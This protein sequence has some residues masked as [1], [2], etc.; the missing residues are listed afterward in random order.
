MKGDI[1]VEN[2]GELATP[3]GFSARRGAEMDSLRIVKKAL[4]VA[5]GGLVA[6]A[7]PA[8]D[9]EGRAALEKA[10]RE[11]AACLD[12]AGRA[13]VPGFVDSHTHFLFAGFRADEFFWRAQGLPYMEIHR[14][15][16]G[17]AK[18]VEAT[19]RC[20]AEELTSLGKARLD[21]M[22]SIGVTTVEGKSGYGL[23]KDTE[24]RQL[25]AMGAL[26]RLSPARVVRT[27]MGPHSLPAEFAGRPAEYIDF[28]I[29]E[30]LPE[31]AARKLADFADIFCEE[32]VFGI[33]DSRRYLSAARASGLGIKIH[34]DEIVRTG[35]ARLAAELGATSADHLLKAAP[36][37]FK[38]MAAAGTIAACLP[39]TAFSLREAYAD[40]RAMVDSGLAVA[41]ASDLNPGSC[42]SQSIPLIFAIAILSMKLSFAETLTAL[43]LNGAAALGLAGELGSLERGKKADFLILDAPEAAHLAYHAAMNIVSLTAIGGE[44]VYRQP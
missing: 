16:G 7:G 2:I 1:I 32:G 19:R 6:Y 20:S 28:V 31:V 40:A 17:I 43:T 30:V 36:E 35:G 14:R 38:A 12:A 23:D 9:S 44:I 4:L 5:R 10:R 3:V 37:D 26:A 39:L 8:E 33:E 24:L 22:L 21:T 11:G 41:L 42:Y 29:G 15:G 27:F 34:A 18:T 13:C 25:E